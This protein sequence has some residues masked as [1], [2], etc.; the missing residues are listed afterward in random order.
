MAE[1]LVNFILPRPEQ[2]Y[3]LCPSFSN[4]HVI[5]TIYY[6]ELVN[7]SQKYKEIYFG[8]GYFSR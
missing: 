4:S 5:A 6:L 8:S 7:V 3:T 1:I 2:R